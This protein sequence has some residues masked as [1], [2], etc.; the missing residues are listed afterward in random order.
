MVALQ[1]DG[2]DATPTHL[3]EVIDLAS[4]EGIKA[5]FTQ[6]EFDSKQPESFAEEI[7]GRVI[8]LTPLSE[9]YIP[10]MRSMAEVIAEELK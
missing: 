6:A 9:D 3:Q 10:S 1:Q 2:K 7:G 4:D 8:E 5:V